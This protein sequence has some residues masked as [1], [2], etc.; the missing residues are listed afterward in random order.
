[1]PLSRHH[2]CS[3]PLC[4]HYHHRGGESHWDRLDFPGHATTDAGPRPRFDQKC[5]RVGRC[6]VAGFCPDVICIRA[7]ARQFVGPVRTLP[8]AD[9]VVG[10]IRDRLCHHGDHT[11]ALG[12]V[13]LSGILRHHRRHL[14]NGEYIP[15]RSVVGKAGRKFWPDG[16]YLRARL[17]LVAGHRRAA[18]RAWPRAPFVAAAILAFANALFGCL[19]LPESL[20]PENRRAIDIRQSNPVAVFAK[21]KARPELSGLVGVSFAD[22]L[23]G[24]VYPAV[25]SCFA[26]ER[27]GW[28]SVMVGALLTACGLC[29]VAIQGG[30]LRPILSHLGERRTIYLGLSIGVMG[31][32]ILMQLTWI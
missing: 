29:F 27:F 21:L 18:R 13:H 17:C 2:A 19:V 7:T 15:G 30:L 4:F 25:W 23:A 24:N 16:R 5:S 10:R 6:P 3:P 32:I 26:I 22:S 9:G 12:A 14:F 20:A 31:F 1:M 11:V 28:S 8:G